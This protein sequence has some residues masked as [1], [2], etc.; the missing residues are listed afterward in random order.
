M[1]KDF[2]KQPGN[3]KGLSQYGM[4]WMLG[5]VAIGLLAGL[6]LYNLSNGSQTETTSSTSTVQATTETTE[7][8]ASPSVAPTNSSMMDKPADNNAPALQSTSAREDETTENPVFSYHAVLPQMEVSLPIAIEEAAS[9]AERKQKA[10]TKKAPPAATQKAEAPTTTTPP[11]KMGKTNGFQLGA[12]KSEA[13]AA[14]LKAKLSSS[15][16][17]T[18]VDKAEVN[19]KTVFRVRLGPATDQ[20]MFNKWQQ[21]LSGMGIS[22]MAV[23]M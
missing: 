14:S 16:L 18:R 12:Y 11:V 6:A 13:Q 21:T 19:G 9:R 15:G 23:R 4:G 17:N 7:A 8:T 5:G 20:D 10:E 22:P 2:K 3:S 1:T